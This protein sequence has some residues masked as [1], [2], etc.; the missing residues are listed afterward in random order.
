MYEENVN[1]KTLDNIFC[2]YDIYL[3]LLPLQ[4]IVMLSSRFVYVVNVMCGGEQANE[5]S[6]W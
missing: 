5:Q 2:M 6:N 3:V 1:W 4:D